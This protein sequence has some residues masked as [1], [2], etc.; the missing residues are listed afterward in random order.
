[1]ES[2][3]SLLTSTGFLIFFI[4]LALIVVGI[5]ITIIK[6]RPEK[7][8]R[9]ESEPEGKK[10][11]VRGGGVVLI[12]PIPIIFGTDRKALLIAVF[13]SLIFMLL[14]IVFLLDS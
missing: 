12:G 3:I 9:E 7:E 8:E 10:S 14:Y 11:K 5:L 2:W 6:A 4:G 1:M 13:A